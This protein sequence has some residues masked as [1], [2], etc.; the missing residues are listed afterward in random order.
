MGE[1]RTIPEQLDDA[2]N[3]EQFAAVLQGLFSALDKARWE[4]EDD[5]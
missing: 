1:R 4:T 3:G 2:Q 5:E